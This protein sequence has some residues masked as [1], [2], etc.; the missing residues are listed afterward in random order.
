M[1]GEK[2]ETGATEIFG[3]ESALRSR[4][5]S[6]RCDKTNLPG[7][8]TSY[9][10]GEKDHFKEPQN[11]DPLGRSSTQPK[12]KSPTISNGRHWGKRRKKGEAKGV[13]S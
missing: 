8:K 10:Q 5:A 7:K 6:G 3:R 9:I 4:T 2:T 11:R 12:G 1:G 13:P